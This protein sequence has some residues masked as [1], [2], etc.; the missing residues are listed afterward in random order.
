MVGD[1]RGVD[2]TNDTDRYTIGI[3]ERKQ[4]LGLSVARHPKTRAQ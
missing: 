3:I 4:W 1:G 2:D